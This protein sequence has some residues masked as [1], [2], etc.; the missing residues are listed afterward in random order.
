MSECHTVRLVSLATVIQIMFGEPNNSRTTYLW[1]S[2]NDT[3]PPRFYSH[4]FFLRPPQT[5]FSSTITD[6]HIYCRE[7]L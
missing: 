7:K 3:I 2:W 4:Y 5:L 6:R 1:N